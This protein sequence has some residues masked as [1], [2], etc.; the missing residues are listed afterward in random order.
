MLRSGMGNMQVTVRDGKHACYSQGWETCMLQSEM[1]NMH[2]TVRDGKHACYIQGW[3]TC[4]L[5]SGMG[6]I[7]SSYDSVVS[8]P[9]VCVKG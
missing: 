3:E 8:K 5:Q 4:M 7:I 2:V 9:L 1:G 6:N